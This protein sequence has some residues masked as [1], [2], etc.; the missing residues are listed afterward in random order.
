MIGGDYVYFGGHYEIMEGDHDVDRVSRHNRSNGA[1]DKSWNPT[2]NGIR[3]INAIDVREDGV[4]I[5]GDFT[6]VDRED[7][8]GF[9]I[10]PGF[11][12]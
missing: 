3:S 7:H 12:D 1:W 6:R 10:F 5:G 11:T 2:V 8:E 9:A 4:H